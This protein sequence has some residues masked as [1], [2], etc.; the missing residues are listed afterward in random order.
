MHIC[1]F[2]QEM[3]EILSVVRYF[4]VYSVAAVFILIERKQKKIFSNLVC[5]QLES[6]QFQEVIFLPLIRC[7]VAIDLY[8]TALHD[9]E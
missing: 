4:L 5:A 1:M 7:C 3:L 2:L 6:E 9:D 8:N